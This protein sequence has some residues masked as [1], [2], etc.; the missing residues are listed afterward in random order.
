MSGIKYDQGKPPMSLVSNEFLVQVA[1]VLE[2][3]KKK[4]SAHNWREGFT[5][6]RPL[7][8][9]L[10]HIHAFADG[11]DKDP[12]SGLSHLA[13]AACCLM[14][15]IEFEKT[16]PHLDNRYKVKKIEVDSSS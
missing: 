10:R 5:W 15:L 4:Y 9:A 12:E 1:K 6:D 2:F 16:H 8:A 14:F 3:G 11:E 7:D 13:H